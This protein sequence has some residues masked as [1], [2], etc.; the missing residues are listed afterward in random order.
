MEHAIDIRHPERPIRS[1]ADPVAR[2]HGSDRRLIRQYRAGDRQAR[3]LMIERYLPFAT[4][5]A[6]RYRGGAEATDDL[7]QI[8][9]IGLV[10]AVDRWDPNRGI[11]F[12]AF[13]MPTIL[14][15]LRHHFRDTTWGVR[16]PR[17][18]QQLSATVE[19]ARDE[20][21]RATGREPTAAQLASNLGRS[22]EDV[23][24]G[25]LAGA[26]RTLRSLEA[27][28]YDGHESVATISD[29]IGR[30]DTGY[31]RADERA[32]IE[33]LTR[34]LD[35]RERAVVALHFQHDF[36]QAEVARHLGCSQPQ[37]SRILR[38]ALDKLSRLAGTSVA[39]A[40]A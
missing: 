28:A 16:P 14:G 12:A 2:A 11:G 3:D 7:V 1:N 40:A 6:R 39:L 19:R 22:R 4:R 24:A 20:M 38:S 37:I 17:P 18:L 13:A 9:A 36:T 32:T 5:L 35:K 31:A 27:P 15:E 8:A 29:A 26:G 30:E 10:K 25:L 23:D 33:R 34:V 21:L